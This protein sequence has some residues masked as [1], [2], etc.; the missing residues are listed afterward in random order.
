MGVDH[1]FNVRNAYKA[2]KRR[3]TRWQFSSSARR[4]APSGEAVKLEP[5]D[6]THMSDTC[7]S[8]VFSLQSYF[9]S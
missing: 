5:P 2:T 4:A 3:K 1:E 7:D 8:G 9:K 6:I